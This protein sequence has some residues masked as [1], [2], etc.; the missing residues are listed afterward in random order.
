MIGRI[1]ESA[2]I[3]GKKAFLVVTTDGSVV[4]AVSQSS[5][6]A[7][8]SDRGTAGAAYMMAFDPAVKPT[9]TGFQLGHYN[10]GQGADES[11]VTGSSPELAAAGIFAN[12]LSYSGQISKLEGV[13]PRVFS[14]EQLNQIIKIY[15]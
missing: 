6:S 13:L 2:K 9:A 11:F 10:T 3:L 4:S 5:N 15:G 8:M 7:W 12:Y 1:L 14:Q